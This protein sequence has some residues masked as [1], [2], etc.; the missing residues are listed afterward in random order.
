MCCGGCVL[1]A[2]GRCRKF[3]GPAAAHLL[4]AL[5]SLQVVKRGRA[6]I[7][8]IGDVEVEYDPKFRLYLQARLEALAVLLGCC[9]ACFMPG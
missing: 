7:L 4:S 2:D 9:H 8:K 3:G 6:L 1:A 5:L